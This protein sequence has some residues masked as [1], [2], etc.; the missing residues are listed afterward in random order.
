MLNDY[1][2]LNQLLASQGEALRLNEPS[3]LASLLPLI[4][5][6]SG[7][8]QAHGQS[9]SAVDEATRR[10]I[11]A[12]LSIIRQRVDANH[13][14]FSARKGR[15]EKERDQLRSARRFACQRVAAKSTG[16]L[17]SQHG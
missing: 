9:L 17:L 11:D 8:V 13:E 10:E 6:Y 1:R 15:L 2:I 14:A 12:L 16:R 7:R 4:E 3:R 5:E